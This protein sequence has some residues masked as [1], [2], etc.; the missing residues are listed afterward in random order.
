MT[1]NKPA[2]GHNKHATLHN[3]MGGNNTIRRLPGEKQ[4]YV[5]PKRGSTKTAPAAA[6]DK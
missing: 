2:P 4:L 6:K 1:C 3:M 5:P